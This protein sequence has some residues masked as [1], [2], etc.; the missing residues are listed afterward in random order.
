M[1]NY[2]LKEG[3]VQFGFNRSRAPIQ[4]FGGAFANGKSTALI[5]KAL[6]LCKDY[7]GSTGLMARATYP[8]LNGTL[9]KDF[10]RWAPRK[11]IKKMPTQEDN[12]CY[13]V[14]GTTVHFR[15]VA[16]KGKNNEDGTT[17][18]NLLS[19]TYDWVIVD[20]IEDPEITYKDFLDL[21]GRLRGQTPYRPSGEEDITMPTCGP[22]WLMVGSNPAQNWFYKEVVYPLILFR[23]KGMFSEKLI[24]DPRTGLPLIELFESDTYANRDNLTEEYIRKLEATYKGQMRERYLLGKWAAFEGLVH[25]GFDHQKHLITRE[26]ALKYLDSC[27]SRHVSIKVVEGYDFG[28]VSPSCYLIA[29]VDDWGRVIII[30]GYYRPE[31]NYD[32]QPAA[33]REIR[34]RYTGRLRAEDAILCD[35]AIFRRTVVAKTDTGDTVAKL[36]RGLDLDMRPAMNDVLPGIA[37]VNA[38]LSDKLD[39]PHIITGDVPSPMLYVVD[40]LSFFTDEIG[41]YYWR[42]NPQGIHIDEPVDNND[43]AMNTTK[44]LLSRLPEPSKIVIPSMAL[45]PQWSFWHEMDESDYR[46]AIRA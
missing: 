18:S 13:L 16:Q 31:F 40:D 33:I 19:A 1:P 38:Y 7:P 24:V 26:Q 32:L 21:I 15:Y 41:S 44:Y 30:D 12:S 28:N 11:W 45:P 23:D 5:I 39:V 37:K 34:G 4:I 20:Q 42:R 46:Q 10:F 17:T 6:Q 14:N 8:K 29:F 43:H 22:G 35:P 9:R 3:S 36:L 25:P 2:H 27:L